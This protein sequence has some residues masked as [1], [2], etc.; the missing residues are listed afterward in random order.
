MAIPMIPSK[1]EVFENYEK[2]LSSK[3]KGRNEYLR[4]AHDFVDYAEGKYD[5]STVEGFLVNQQRKRK[6]SDNSLKLVFG[7]VRTL[8]RRNDFE[9]PFNRGEGPT[10]RESTINAPALDPRTVRRMIAAVKISNDLAAMA[11]LALSTTYGLRQQ[12]MINIT[13]A[14][15]N[16]EP[17]PIR[18]KDQTIYIATLKHGRERTHA[19]PDQI[20]YYLEH[21]DFSIPRSENY[22]WNLWGKME[23]MIDLP[24]YEN[25]GWHAAR[26]SL[27]TLLLRI[28][29]EATVYSFM[30][31]KQATSSNMALRYS[32]MKFVG[33]KDEVVE[34]QG[35]ALTVDQLI[36]S[37]NEDGTWKHPFIEAWR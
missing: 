22:M 24:H 29:P 36:F 26:R 32:R 21:F 13:M 31:W 20:I 12:E 23:R 11:F 28:F 3:G 35:D 27:N 4:W 15:T 14:V 9:W 18:L 8:F 30:R 2:R 1:E 37:Q 34:L 19:I 6:Y 7:V 16:N 25:V 10:V 17:N 33:E 5:R